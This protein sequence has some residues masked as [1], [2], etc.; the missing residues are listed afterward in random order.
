M[1][2]GQFWGTPTHKDII[3]FENFLLLLENYRSR[4][5]TVYGFSIILIEVLKSES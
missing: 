2:P 4:S 1:L 5:R 3:E